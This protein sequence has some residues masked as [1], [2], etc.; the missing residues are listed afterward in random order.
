MIDIGTGI[1]VG[2]SLVVATGSSATIG[3]VIARDRVRVEGAL[4]VTTFTFAGLNQD[5]PT[6]IAYQH[7]TV[8]GTARLVGP[9]AFPGFVLIREAGATLTF[10]GLADAISRVLAHG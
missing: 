1:D 10:N 4:A 2:D 3:S 7:V 9:T 8:N 5:I 6:S